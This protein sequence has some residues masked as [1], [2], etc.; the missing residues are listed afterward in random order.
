[1]GGR[2]H[3]EFG[4]ISRAENSANWVSTQHGF[5]PVA[6]ADHLIE[7]WVVLQKLFKGIKASGKRVFPCNHSEDSVD[8]DNLL[9]NDFLGNLID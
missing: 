6:V 7:K 3:Y 4:S 5:L 2:K 9:F 1:M 8:D